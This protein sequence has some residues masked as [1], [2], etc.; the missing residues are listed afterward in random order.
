MF[1][2]LNCIS[3]MSIINQ[4]TGT[5]MVHITAFLLLSDYF[6]S[7][8]LQVCL[9]WVCRQRICSDSHGF[10]WVSFQRKADKGKSVTFQLFI[11]SYL[12]TRGS[13]I[14]NFA[15]VHQNWQKYHCE[16]ISVSFTLNKKHKQYYLV[17][18]WIQC[19]QC[20]LRHH[21]YRT[22]TV[23][24]FSWCFESQ[25]QNYLDHS[26]SSGFVLIGLKGYSV[27]CA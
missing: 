20:L 17:K 27:L 1:W 19:I 9:Y 12:L 21:R 3:G 25:W 6:F 23:G 7:S 26:S 13:H 15:V 16:E 8:P 22:D 14:E 11:F 24:K 5:V 18:L 2:C 10:G 4:D